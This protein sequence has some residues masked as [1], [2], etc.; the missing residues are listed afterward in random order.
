MLA[1]LIINSASGTF[2]GHVDAGCTVDLNCTNL[3]LETV[4]NLPYI[5]PGLFQLGKSVKFVVN[6]C[7]A[8][9]DGGT[10]QSIKGKVG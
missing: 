1:H 2:T 5:I 8:N 9:P 3:V 6:A 10:N 4:K 7:S